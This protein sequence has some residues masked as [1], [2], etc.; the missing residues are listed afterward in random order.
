M[1]RVSMR[2]CE[3]KPTRQILPVCCA[4]AAG[5]E[6]SALAP[7]TTSNLRRLSIHH[8]SSFHY[9]PL[10]YLIVRALDFFLPSLISPPTRR[11]CPDQP[12]E[13]ARECG[14]GFIT[15]VERYRRN[16]RMALAQQICSRLHS[17]LREIL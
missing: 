17:P 9:H 5:G 1:S 10:R 8:G 4:K 3:R 15:Y 16:G 6:M 2:R 12:F 13:R 7:S 14:F 11:R